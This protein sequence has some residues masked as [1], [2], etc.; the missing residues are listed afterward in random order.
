MK[1]ERERER[2]GRVDS[3]ICSSVRETQKSY[4]SRFIIILVSYQTV[5]TTLVHLVEHI[6]IRTSTKREL[7]TKEMKEKNM[8]GEERKEAWRTFEKILS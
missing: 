3:S 5:R 7:L 8:N 6:V 4:F 1:R 2:H